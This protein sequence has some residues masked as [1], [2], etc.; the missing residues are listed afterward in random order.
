[1]VRVWMVSARMVDARS[2]WWLR[3]RWGLVGSVGALLLS[4]AGC[5]GTVEEGTDATDAT[6]GSNGSNGTGGTP[7]VPDKCV[8]NYQG[9]FAGD[10]RGNLTGALDAHA[11]FDVTFGLSDGQTASG[12]GSVADD[13]TIDVAVGANRVTGQFNFNRCRASGDWVFGEARGTWK[14]A[15]N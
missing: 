6:S 5:G 15:R 9:S 3:R 14:A 2:K 1:M 4:L 11:D 7:I 12:S 13:G 10:I 8:G